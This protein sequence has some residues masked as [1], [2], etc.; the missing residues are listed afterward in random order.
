MEGREVEGLTVL[1]FGLITNYLR[2]TREDKHLNIWPQTSLKDDGTAM[3]QPFTVKVNWEG[4]RV[5]HIGS[6][7]VK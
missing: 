3:N 6:I 5:P 2:R 7:Y 4:G 1:P